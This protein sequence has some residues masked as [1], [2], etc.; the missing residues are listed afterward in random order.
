MVLQQLS[1]FEL[2]KLVDELQFLVDSK[3]DKIY[4]LSK[5][6]LIFNFHKTHVGK[7]TLRVILPNL[8]YITKKKFSA[9][10]LPHGYCMFLRKYLGTARLRSVSMVGSER[11]LDFYFETKEEKYHLFFEFF[12]KGN[13]ILTDEMLMI[14]SPL[15]NQVWSERT[16]RGGVKYEFPDK[17]FD[18]FNIEFDQF[19]SILNNATNVTDGPNDG[20]LKKLTSFGLGKEYSLEILKRARVDGA[21]TRLTK[22]ETES[23]FNS[24]KKF[25]REKPDV[26]YYKKTGK[27]YVSAISSVKKYSSLEDVFGKVSD[28]MM[29]DND[30]DKIPDDTAISFPSINVAFD[31]SIEMPKPEEKSVE[32]EKSRSKDKLA[33]V[34]DAQ[35]RRKEELEHVATENQRKGELIYENYSLVHDVLEQINAARK[36]MPWA[37]IKEKLKG[38]KIITHVD[39][40]TGTI[41][42]D[43]GE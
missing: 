3:V 34:I 20:I 11:I 23:L 6:D 15:D 12:D 17:G 27:V 4:M 1:G 43:L 16:I 35:T 8:L 33:K 28:D 26:F 13:A 2:K 25:L 24:V 14:K 18:F 32:G 21:K 9:P 29:I 42:V 39:D 37:Q 5:K 19:A 31:F 40:K 7:Q 22:D 30:F 10:E 38:H 41:T 36:N